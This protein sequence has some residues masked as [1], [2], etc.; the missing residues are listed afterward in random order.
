MRLIFSMLL[1]FGAI[2]VAT[3][4]DE[5]HT[6]ARFIA[7]QQ[8]IVKGEIFL[9]GVHLTMDDHW[10]TYWENP[11][12]SGLPTTLKV[13]PVDGLTIEPLQFPYPERYEDEMG[14]VTFG[15][16]DEALLWARAVYNGSASEIKLNGLIEWLECKQLCIAG[17]HEATLALAVGAEAKPANAAQFEKYVNKTPIPFSDE[18]P[19]QFD[20]KL[21]FGAELWEGSV[22][23]KPKEAGWSTDP[24]KFTFYQTVPKGDFAELKKADLTIKDGAY[25]FDLSYEAFEEVG[26]D[27]PVTGVMKLATNKGTYYSR[28]NLWPVSAQLGSIAANA[29]SGSTEA[30]DAAP[31]ALAPEGGVTRGFLYF[32]LMAF[33]GGIILNL[34]P[35]VLPVLSLK[36]FALISDAGESAMARTRNAWVYTL[37]IMASF[38]VISLFFALSKVFGEQVGIGFQL[39]N[40]GF[41]IFMCALLFIMALS[42]FGVF[43]FG[44]PNSDKLSNLS[45][46]SG[47]QGAFWMGV[48]M[49]LLST[50]CTAPFLGVAYGWAL[51][52]SIV[53]ILLIF[54]VIALGLAIPYVILCY[55]PA[56]LKFLPKPGAWMEHMKVGMGFMMA[57]TLVWLL[58]V[59]AGLTGPDGVIGVLALL[60]AIG[61]G[62]YLI[63]NTWY[64]GRRMFGVISALVL[65]G[66]GYQ[67]GMRDLFQL[68]D[69]TKARDARKEALRL[70]LLAE[71]GG[72]TGDIYAELEKLV[73]TA[74]EIAWVPYTADTLDY[75]RDKGRLVFLDFTADWCLTCKANERLVIDTGKIR[76]LFADHEVVVMRGDYTEMKEEHTQFINSF[77]RAGVPL[78]VVY[79]GQ[80]EPILLPE[81]ITAGIVNDAVSDAAVTLKQA[82]SSN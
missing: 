25:R 72:A 29:A 47:A 10:H 53:V 5:Y 65:L 19:Y 61:M 26:P 58:S 45:Q 36:V 9:L 12:F 24:S 15:H 3:A 39:S 37:G 63:G 62:A 77:N 73:T 52:Q 23:L 33:I 4:E 16:D 32:A 74:E 2:F 82:A 43:E 71:G 17:K 44:A 51:S 14:F 80:G 60:V 50:P 13:E 67:I 27:Q 56:L 8:T 20:A 81:T 75:F 48:L 70:E 49:T 41:V 38:L 66:A 59:L 64:S 7:N 34:M 30:L 40:P 31:S 76:Q 11:G 18:A 22:T 35:C 79:P 69:P 78:Y 46:K 28:I 42:F 57:G 21:N 54:Q 68:S 6:E 55:S 1:T